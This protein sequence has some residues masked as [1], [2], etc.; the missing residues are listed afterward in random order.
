MGVEMEGVGGR[1][2]GG[3]VGI[4]GSGSRDSV[5]VECDRDEMEKMEGLGGKEVKECGRDVR[6]G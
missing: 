1:D 5:G 4:G 2:A 3:A 6:G